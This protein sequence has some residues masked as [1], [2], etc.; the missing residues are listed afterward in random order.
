MFLRCDCD[1]PSES[2]Y[3]FDCDYDSDCNYDAIT[4]RSRLRLRCYCDDACV[5]FPTKDSDGEMQIFVLK[6]D[7]ATL[8]LYVD[9]SDTIG[10]VKAQ[11][12]GKEGIPPKEQ[13]LIYAGTQLDDDRKTLSAC[14]IQTESTL[15]LVP[16]LF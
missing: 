4:V 6:P 15:N 2:D 7:G 1:L 11:I 3:D 13:R 9:A 12:R 8:T 16:S 14:N 5:H 10:H